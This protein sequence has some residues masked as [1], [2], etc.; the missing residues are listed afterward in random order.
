M[1]FKVD[2]IQAMMKELGQTR[3]VVK[4]Y[5]FFTGG[6]L[7]NAYWVADTAHQDRRVSHGVLSLEQAKSWAFSEHEAWAKRC[8]HRG[9]QMINCYL[10][11]GAWRHGSACTC[12]KEN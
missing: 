7:P 11:D 3:Y 4:P 5:T 9:G 1:C 8:L 6:V 2:E 10:I 12:P